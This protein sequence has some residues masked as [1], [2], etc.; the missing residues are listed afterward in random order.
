M[1]TVARKHSRSIVCIAKQRCA[2]HYGR[3]ELCRGV[4]VQC[5]DV[6][7]THQIHGAVGGTL[8]ESNIQVIH[9]APRNA[10]CL[11]KYDSNK[12]KYAIGQLF[13]SMLASMP[14]TPTAD[15]IIASDYPA[16]ENGQTMSA[17]YKITNYLIY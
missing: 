13:A 7:A 16:N 10:V 15:V 6:F 14:R 4:A 2:G 5:T 1:C 17:R 11:L 12:T 9:G 3:W 8:T